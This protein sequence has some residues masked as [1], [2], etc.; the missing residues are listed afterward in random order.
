MLR[1]HLFLL[2]LLSSVLFAPG[3]ATVHSGRVAAHVDAE[4]HRVYGAGSPLGLVI[5]G[6]EVTD[7]ASPYFGF[8]ELTFENT[9]ASWVRI[10]K[11][12]MNFGTPAKDQNVLVPWGSDIDTWRAATYQRN[13]IREANTRTALELVAIGGALTASVARHKPAGAIGGLAAL[14]AIGALTTQAYA[15][16]VK[17]AETTAPFP[18]NHLLAVPFGVPPALFSKRWILLNTQNRPE[19]GC[20][21]SMYLDYEAEGGQKDRVEIEFKPPGTHSEWQR[22]CNG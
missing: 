22:A 20:I 2:P 15:D 1:R 9:T 6:R 3:C 7:L 10:T 4:G 16:R 18:D 19:A 11:I 17:E 21:R 13:A 12:D 14:G 8:V 5:S